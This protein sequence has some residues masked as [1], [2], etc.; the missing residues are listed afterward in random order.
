MSVTAARNVSLSVRPEHGGRDALAQLDGVVGEGDRR[1]VLAVGAPPE[2]P[3]ARVLGRELV[4]RDD[5]Y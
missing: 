1:D 2:H 3:Q 4:G 5:S